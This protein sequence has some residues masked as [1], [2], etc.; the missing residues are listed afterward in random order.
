MI[1][2]SEDSAALTAVRSSEMAITAD[3]LVGG[4]RREFWGYT[5]TSAA[6]LV[7]IYNYILDTTSA[8]YRDFIIGTLQGSTDT[9][10]PQGAAAIARLCR[11]LS[12]LVPGACP[13]VWQ[14]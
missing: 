14:D 1:A 8:K 9:T 2:I 4:D 6:D 11:E 5:V 7:Q 3:G 13:E 10:W 12:P